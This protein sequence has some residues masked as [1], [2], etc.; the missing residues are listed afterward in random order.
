MEN[1]KVDR[2]YKE[3]RTLNRNMKRVLQ[4]RVPNQY[5]G[6]IPHSQL[7]LFLLI[8]DNEGENQSFFCEEMDVR[9]SSLTE[10]LTK[11]DQ[12][13]LIEKRKDENDLRITKVYLSEHGKDFLDKYKN[14]IKSFE[15][16]VFESLTTEER[17]ELLNI[18]IKLNENLTEENDDYKAFKDEMKNFG[19]Q[20]KNFAFS[21]KDDIVETFDDVFDDAK[22][23]SYNA[24]RY[25]RHHKPYCGPGHHHNRDCQNRHTECD[26]QSQ[27]DKP[28]IVEDEPSLDDD[29]DNE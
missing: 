6:A 5:K 25:G 4:Q 14:E 26:E 20:M 7:N 1:N 13:G 22:Y 23:N 21:L 9:P 2:L 17:E 28:H 8:A 29:K 18:V 16:N 19:R 15:D 24:R 27:Y 11:L 10:L 3:L 12:A